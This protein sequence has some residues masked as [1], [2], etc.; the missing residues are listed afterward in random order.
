VRRTHRP[1]MFMSSRPEDSHL[2]SVC[3]SSDAELLTVC[4]STAVLE[5]EFEPSVPPAEREGEAERAAL[6]TVVSLAGDRGFASLLLCHPVCLSVENL[7]FV[8]PGQRCLSTPI[9]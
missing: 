5:S 7:S 2:R 9:P 4:A 8:G 6:K 1:L 3:S